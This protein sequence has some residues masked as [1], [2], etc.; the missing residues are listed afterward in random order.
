ME[1]CVGVRKKVAVAI[2]SEASQSVELKTIKL[3]NC[4]VRSSFGVIGYVLST[5]ALEESDI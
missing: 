5:S 4:V 1:G 3:S 2:D